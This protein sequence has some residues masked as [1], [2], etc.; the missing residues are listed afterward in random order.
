MLATIFPNDDDDDDECEA[1]GGMRTVGRNRR[2]R[3]KPTLFTINLIISL[4]TETW[5]G[6]RART[7]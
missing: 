5:P 6:D 2:T 1:V 3:R 4:G 7:I